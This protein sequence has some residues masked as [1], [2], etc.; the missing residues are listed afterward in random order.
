M[1]NL[2]LLATITHHTVFDLVFLALMVDVSHGG[3]HHAANIRDRR[4][5]NDLGNVQLSPVAVFSSS[6]IIVAV[7]GR[8]RS[9][10]AAHKRKTNQNE[11]SDT[12]HD[13]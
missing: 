12:F 8:L 2:A 5:I 13:K 11:G 6:D 9:G 4:D 1:N 3:W 7:I 10:H